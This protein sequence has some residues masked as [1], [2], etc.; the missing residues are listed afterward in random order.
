[1]RAGCALIGGET[2]E[3]PGV[4]PDD[5]Y[6]LAGFCI[7]MADYD[8][9]ITGDG[10]AA[11]DVILGMASSGVHSNGFS[12]IRKVFGV[13]AAGTLSRYVPELSK[14][15]GQELLT[16][17]TIYVKPLLALMK[18]VKVKAVCHITGGGFYENLP[19]MLPG[20]LRAVVERA[21]VITPAIFGLIAREGGI[22][23]RDMWNTFNMGVG[24]ALAVAPGDA[25]AALDS[26]KASGLPA[27]VI[28][29]VRPG[30]KGL[31]IL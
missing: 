26:I 19:R 30:G 8:G 24:M 31:D 22:P 2:A 5:D 29:E 10:A 14:T 20:G 1:M 17:T 7:G 12:L 21:A 15:L 4:M 3:H 6:D 25:D 13:G 27:S 16:P 9:I 18:T 23:E 11:G 28:G